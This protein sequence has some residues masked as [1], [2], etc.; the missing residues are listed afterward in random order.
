MDALFADTDTQQYRMG[1][2]VYDIEGNAF[3]YAKFNEAVVVGDLLTHVADAAWDSGIV[4]DGAITT[5]AATNVMHIDTITTEMTQNQYA[6]YY[7]SQGIAASKG[8]FFRIAYHD[9][10]A[11]SGEGDLFLE[12]IIDEA[13]GDGAALYIFHPYLME[14]TDA[15][16]ET[17]RGVAHVAHTS[18]YFGFYQCGGFVQR[19]LCDGSNGAAVVLNEPIVPYASDAGQGQGMAGSAEADIMEAANS[20]LIALRAS[21]TDAGYVPAMFVREL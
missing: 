9:A 5:A 19:V 15:G 7:V 11:A 6:G 21:S 12:D 18:G 17:I 14:E 10:M 8:R 2:K 1:Q 13:F 16:T 20:P 3:R 4:T